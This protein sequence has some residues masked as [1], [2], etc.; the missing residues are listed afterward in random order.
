VDY[1]YENA[2]YRQT[3]QLAEQIAQAINGEYSAILCYER[4]AKMARNE[5]VRKQILEIR[6]D[7]IHHYN[8]FRQIYT[9]LT[10]QNPIVQQS[11]ECP[12]HYLQ[13]LEFALIDEQKTVDFYLKIAKETNDPYI[14]EAFKFAAADEQNHA[15]WFLYFLA[16]N[17]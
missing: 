10:G 4:I 16:M 2:L 6:Q 14:K 9:A 8:T 15:V 7:E 12:N 1:F 13:G 5:T 17:R 3:S 11:E